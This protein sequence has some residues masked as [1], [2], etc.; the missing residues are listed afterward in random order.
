MDTTAF[1]LPDVPSTTGAVRRSGLAADRARAAQT[2][3]ALKHACQEMESLFINQ[4]LTQMR[5]AIPKGGLM[6]ESNAEEMFTAMHD[7]ELARTM[8]GAGGLGLARILMAQLS[9]NPAT[10]DNDPDA[11]GAPPLKVSPER[12][13]NPTNRQLPDAAG[14]ADVA[15]VASPDTHHHRRGV[16]WK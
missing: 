1:T 5:Q 7:T 16:P 11:P 13:D 12:A 10:K 14:A 8:A 15:T 3:D 6:G 4:L 9:Q 2:P